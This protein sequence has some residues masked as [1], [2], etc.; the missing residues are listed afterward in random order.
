MRS[1]RNAC[2]RAW[3]TARREH[4]EQAKASLEAAAT[5]AL[6]SLEAAVAHADFN[7][8]RE[9]LHTQLAAL[10]AVHEQRQAVASATEEAELEKQLQLQQKREQLMLAE[11]VQAK[12]QIEAWRNEQAKLALMALENETAVGA[13]LAFPRCL[14]SE[15]LY[16][17]NP[18][19]LFLRVS[20]VLGPIPS[21][22]V[23]VWTCI[24]YLL[25]LTQ[26][27]P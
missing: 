13:L 26:S 20:P 10:R 14:M 1:K 25:P 7:A 2:H 18:V 23:R 3:R 9:A 4:L 27:I 24:L 17:S 6:E 16:S 5:S 12:Q 11:M 21:D 22:S 15:C 8:E 19:S